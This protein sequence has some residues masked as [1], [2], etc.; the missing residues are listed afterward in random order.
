MIETVGRPRRRDLVAVSDR[1]RRDRCEKPVP[2]AL[3]EPVGAAA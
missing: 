1:R 2:T 3:V